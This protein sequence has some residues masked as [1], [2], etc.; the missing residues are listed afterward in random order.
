MEVD[1]VSARRQSGQVADDSDAGTGL[2]QIEHADRSTGRI[3]HGSGAAGRVSPEHGLAASREESGGGE[4]EQQESRCH[5]S[6]V[7]G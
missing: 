7:I 6:T 1:A 3:V 5:V 4:C 2:L